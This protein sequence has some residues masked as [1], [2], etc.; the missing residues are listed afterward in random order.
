MKSSYPDGWCKTL[1][2]LLNEKRRYSAEEMGWARAYER[3]QLKKSGARFP[4]NGEIYEAIHDVEIGCLTHWRAPFTGGQ[5]VLLPAGTKLRV[6]VNSSDAEP[7]GIYAL[8]LEYE[9]MQALLVPSLDVGAEN[10]DGYSI[11]IRT[12]QLNR[13][14]RLV[15][16]ETT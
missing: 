7:I 6:E 2:D 11:S 4:V 9:R 12:V 16:V 5:R 10:Y 14:F 15:S 1:E 13:D 8:P 3:E